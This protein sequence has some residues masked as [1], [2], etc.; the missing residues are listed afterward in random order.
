MLSAHHQPTGCNQIRVVVVCQN[1]SEKGGKSLCDLQIGST[2]E[3]CESQFLYPGSYLEVVEVV[4][5]LG[6]FDSG[7]FATLNP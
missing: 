6:S 1:I 5:E 2:L 7:S 4:W 3:C